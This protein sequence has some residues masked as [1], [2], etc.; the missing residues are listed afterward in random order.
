[1][2]H[3]VEFPD[4]RT[5]VGEQIHVLRDLPDFLVVVPRRVVDPLGH[6]AAETDHLLANI[7]ELV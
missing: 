1:M 3:D 6:L 5:R 4:V 7:L 2:N